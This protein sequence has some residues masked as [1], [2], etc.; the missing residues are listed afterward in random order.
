[1]C[2]GCDR[3]VVLLSLD[4]TVDGDRREMV[5][6]KNLFVSRTEEQPIEDR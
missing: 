1:M 3:F 6:K 4:V 5:E 2:F